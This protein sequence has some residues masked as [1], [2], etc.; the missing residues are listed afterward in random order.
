M[1]GKKYLYP[2]H[3]PKRVA[4]IPVCA[5][6]RQMRRI[7]PYLVTLFAM[8]MLDALWLSQM[9]Q[10]LYR[11]QLASILA[12]GFRPLP[13][14]SFYLVQTLGI[15]IFV[16]WRARRWSEALALG[17]AFGIFTYATYDLTNWATLKDWSLTL[18]VVD[19]LW[20]GVLTSLAAAAGYAVARRNHS[21]RVFQKT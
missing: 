2:Q 4:K 9:S 10:P 8:L 17:A 3:R 19:M 6:I 14:I 11:A 5:H 16:V 7:I 13:A 20:G 18:S 12:P 1:A 21:S 15:Q